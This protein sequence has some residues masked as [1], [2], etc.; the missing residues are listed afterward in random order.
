MSAMGGGRADAAG[1]LAALG[2]CT[3]LLGG[4]HVSIRFVSGTID[5]ATHADGSVTAGASDVAFTLRL[6]PGT[7]PRAF[8]RAGF[9]PPRLLRGQ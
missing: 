2:G 6:A 7:W 4:A 1:A 5:V 3:L 9:S 8:P